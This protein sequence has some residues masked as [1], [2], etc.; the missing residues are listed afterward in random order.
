MDNNRIIVTDYKDTKR[1]YLNLSNKTQK[2]YM[3]KLDEKN[4]IVIVGYHC[5]DSNNPPILVSDNPK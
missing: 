1:R 5:N 4:R 2:Q 3:Y